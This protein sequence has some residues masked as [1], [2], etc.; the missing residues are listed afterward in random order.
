M[1]GLASIVL[2]GALHQS[3]GAAATPA[4]GLACVV[5]DATT[6][7][8]TELYRST[9]GDSWAKHDLWTNENTSVCN[10]YGV[11]C[12]TGN[13]RETDVEGWG[14]EP[15]GGCSVLVN[16]D[17]NNLTGSIPVGLSL[18]TSITSLILSNNYIA[19]RLPAWKDFARLATL[20]V[21]N[22]FLYGAIPFD[23]FLFTSLIMLDLTGNRFGPIAGGF[24]VRPA[25]PKLQILLLASNRLNTFP[26]SLCMLESLVTLS[27]DN[28]DLSTSVIPPEIG[29]LARLETLSLQNCGIGGTIPE[30]IGRLKRLSQGL[31]LPNNRLTGLLPP[32][33]ANL[34]NLVLLDVTG[35]Y[36]YGTLPTGMSKMAALQNLYMGNNLLSGAIPDDLFSA[37]ALYYL[38]LSHNRLGMLPQAFDCV[39][40]ATV[41]LDNNWLACGFPAALA[42]CASVDTLNLENNLLGGPLPNLTRMHSLRYFF[43]TNNS[44]EGTVPFFPDGVSEVLLGGNNFVFVPD[45]V[46]AGAV[47]SLTRLELQENELTGTLPC[48]LGNATGLQELNLMNNHLTGEIPEGMRKLGFLNRVLVGGNKLQGGILPM[49]LAADARIT[50]DFHDNDFTGDFPAWVADHPNTFYLDVGHNHLV[51]TLPASIGALPYLAYLDVCANRFHGTLPETIGTGPLAF[52]GADNNEFVGSLPLAIFNS[53]TFDYLSVGYNNLDGTLPKPTENSWLQYV[54]LGNNRL[55]GTIPEGFRTSALLLQGNRLGGSLP[56]NLSVSALLLHDNHLSCQLPNVSSYTNS[57]IAVVLPAVGKKLYQCGRVILRFSIAGLDREDTFWTVALACLFVQRE[58]EGLQDGQQ[59]QQQQQQQ[60]EE[61]EQE[62]QQQHHQQPRSQP[63]RP[64][65]EPRAEP[66]RRG[67][68][69]TQGEGEGEREGTQAGRLRV[70]E[71]PPAALPRRSRRHGAGACLLFLLAGVVSCVPS[72][73]YSAS[74]SLPPHNVF[75]FGPDSFFFSFWFTSVCAPATLLF[76]VAV[77]VPKLTKLLLSLGWGVIEPQ[78]LQRTVWFWRVT[79]SFIVPI[80]VLLA[81]DQGCGQGWA[82]LWCGC[83]EEGSCSG[84]PLQERNVTGRIATEL[85]V[86]LEAT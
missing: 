14:V 36:L 8:L 39:S 54:N 68:H 22:N 74:H 37:P 53:S 35:N 1:V 61:E 34:T 42:N 70:S 30:S 49:A 32:S 19:G 84:M 21:A 46:F 16:L 45:N 38:D 13:D 43:A 27:L 86:V 82:S 58:R 5:D 3:S 66:R 62:Q 65:P 11:T 18:S 25:M 55:S 26:A 51:G 81:L 79:V 78:V 48:W 33:V 83:T 52:F 2:L 80:A 4:P 20:N 28:N 69:G 10:W 56:T 47:G 6:R 63:Q 67:E 29:M 15:A 23:Y 85:A 72:A 73:L 75:G 12:L 31:K 24:P 9:E 41:F 64:P 44:L 7:A 71:P 40:L 77:A 57:S 50:L 59:Q 76:C 17:S 60:Q